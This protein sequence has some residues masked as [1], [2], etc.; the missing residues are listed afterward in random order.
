MSVAIESLIPR[1]DGIEIP[2]VLLDGT[3]HI[4]TIGTP[5]VEVDFICYSPY[6]EMLAINNKKFNGEPFRIE[7]EGEYY[8]GKI[9][10]LKGW[11]IK[12]D[13]EINRI[14]QTTIILVVSDSGV[15]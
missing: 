7:Y 14:Y 12:I 9:K 6:S 1:L 4:Q 8:I 3:Y 13:S 15:V 2:N 11:N 10:D 5:R